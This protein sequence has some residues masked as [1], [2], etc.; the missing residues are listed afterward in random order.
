MGSFSGTNTRD[1][2]AIAALKEN[3]S[4]TERQMKLVL[5]LIYLYLEMKLEYATLCQ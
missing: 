2:A 1:F 5:S 3:G 4:E